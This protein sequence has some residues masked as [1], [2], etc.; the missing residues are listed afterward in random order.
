MHVSEVLRQLENLCSFVPIELNLN[1]L[2]VL[3]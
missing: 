3:F 2:A 1:E